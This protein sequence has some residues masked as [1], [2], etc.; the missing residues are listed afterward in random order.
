M[1]E[2]FQY[3]FNS[4]DDLISPE[5]NQ[6]QDDKQVYKPDIFKCDETNDFKFNYNKNKEKPLIIG[7]YLDSTQSSSIRKAWTDKKMDNLYT[8]KEQLLFDNVR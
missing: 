8:K 1:Q 3:K 5:K 4:G 2:D 7:K 6:D